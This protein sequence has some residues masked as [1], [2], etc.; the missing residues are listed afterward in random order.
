MPSLEE[1]FAA[2]EFRARTALNFEAVVAL[3]EEA[4]QRAADLGTKTVLHGV[5]GTTATFV[6]KRLGAL[7]VGE[8]EL[9][10]VESDAGANE[11]QL[12]AVDY[13]VARDTLFYIIPIGPRESPALPSFKRFSSDLKTQLERAVA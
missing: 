11:V 9:M 4:A 13:L 12:R 6:V 8:F 5:V 7:T 3:A 2:L 1:K 10:M